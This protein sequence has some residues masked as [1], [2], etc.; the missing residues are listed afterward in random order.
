MY[1][2]QKKRKLLG[3]WTNPLEQIAPLWVCVQTAVFS[4]TSQNAQQQFFIKN[5]RA[6]V[7][8]I[9]LK[10]WSRQWGHFTQ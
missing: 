5:K 9:F 1:I 10:C 8:E 4:P 2:L 3:M 6:K 7:S